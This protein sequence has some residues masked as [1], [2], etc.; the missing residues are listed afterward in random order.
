MHNQDTKKWYMWSQRIQASFELF[1]T[2]SDR[3]KI[4]FKQ[5]WKANFGKLDLPFVLAPAQQQS[6]E[7]FSSQMQCLS[8][9]I[10]FLQLIKREINIIEEM[11]IPEPLW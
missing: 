10:Y 6:H 8:V 1:W 5:G 7:H 9:I 2:V 11:L 4:E 3:I